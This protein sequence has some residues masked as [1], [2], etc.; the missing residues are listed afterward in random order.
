MK[1]IKNDYETPMMECIMFAEYDIVT[2]SGGNSGT[3]GGSN[4][5]DDLLGAGVN[6]LSW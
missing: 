3:A 5:F 1:P 4:S 6:N 2:L